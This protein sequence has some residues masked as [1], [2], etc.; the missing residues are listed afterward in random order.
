MFYGNNIAVFLENG[1][2][3]IWCM[4]VLFAW[5]DSYQE[6]RFVQF[7]EIHLFRLEFSFDHQLSLLKNTLDDIQNN[8]PIVCIDDH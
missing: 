3:L 8:L 1:R 4:T 2:L 5:F 6:T 7:L